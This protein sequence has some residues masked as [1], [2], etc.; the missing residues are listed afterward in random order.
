MGARL[1]L[2]S[3]PQAEALDPCAVPALPRGVRLHWCSVRE[4]WF[5]QAPE[6]AVK[7]DQIAAAIL[8]RIDGARNLGAVVDKLAKDFSAPRDQIDRDVQ[9]FLSD[10]MSRRMLDLRSPTAQG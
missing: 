3:D 10:L 8:E 1:H 6:R 4:T 7:L 9:R 5:I 2:M